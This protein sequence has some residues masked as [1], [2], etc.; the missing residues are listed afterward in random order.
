MDWSCLHKYKLL[1]LKMWVVDRP[2]KVTVVLVFTRLLMATIATTVSTQSRMISSAEPTATP[3]IN[4]D[5]EEEGEEGEETE[6]VSK[7][8]ITGDVEEDVAVK[9][10]LF[11]SIDFTHIND[12]V[13]HMHSQCPD[14]VLCKSTIYKIVT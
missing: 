13:F 7:V 3:G 1:L 9:T 10:M 14:T 12:Q 4:N 8:E 5:E 2:F 11:I 6:G